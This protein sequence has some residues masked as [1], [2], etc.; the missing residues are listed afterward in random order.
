M[1]N[2]IIQTLGC[3]L[4]QIESESIAKFFSDNKFDVSLIPIT[5]SSKINSDVAVCVVNTCSVTQKSEQKARR[6]IRLLLEKFPFACVIITGCYAE[7]S[8]NSLL[9]M[10]ERVAVLPGKKKSRMKKAADFLRCE[11]SEKEFSSVQENFS[12]KEFANKIQTQIFDAPQENPNL[13][14]ATFSL[15]TENFL[16]HSR[17]S[18]KIQDGCNGNCSYCAIKNARGKSV[19]LDAADVIERV[20]SLE[21]SGQAEV[22][23][24][25][26]NVAQY[27]STYGGKKIDFSDL[28]LILLEKT[29]KICFRI[30]SIWPTFVT[31][32]FCDAVSNDR[33]MPH[34]HLSVQSGSDK[35]LS[36]MHRNYTAADVLN[37]VNKIRAVKKEPFLACD[38]IAGF[39]GETED[40]FS[41]TVALMH[42]CNF[43]WIHAFPFSARPNTDA[44]EMKPKV[45][46]SVSGKRVEKLIGIAKENK[47]AYINSFSGKIVNAV[48]E[49]V[50]G[51]KNVL[52]PKNNFA[53]SASTSFA[54]QRII[55]AVTENFLHCEIICKNK[56]PS[57]GEKIEVKIISPLI[58]NIAKGSDVDV[59][60]EFV[61]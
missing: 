36:A 39:P 58:E 50:R 38:I 60:A 42:D 7:L 48:A 34:F 5:A 29:Q 12:A 31:D 11:F 19:S 13:A 41:D 1:L 45:P 47:A 54:N 21:K 30:S 61:R 46:Q 3:R 43:S 32:K 9:E 17:A 53:D 44:F 24:T 51:Q 55:H 56:I 37:A 59:M 22:V 14:E 40:D 57:P 15:A 25:G 23:F 27:T 26:V 16:A 6:L 8:K 33:V 10:S 35:I 28:I 20:V 18:I 49:S 4:N 2:V 52:F